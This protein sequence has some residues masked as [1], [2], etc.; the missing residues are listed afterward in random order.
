MQ[1][2][3]LPVPE[4]AADIDPAWLTGAL[5]LGGHLD[6]AAVIAVTAVP[7]GTGQVANCSRLTITYD[8]PTG[9][10]GTMIAKTGNTDPAL[11]QAIKEHGVYE[12]EVG[13]YRELAPHLDIPVARSYFADLDVD[14]GTFVLLLDD[15]APAAQGD[16][17]EGCSP[18]VATAAVEALVG[19]H[20]PRWGD[21]TL[22]DLAWLARDRDAERRARMEA[23]PVVWTSFQK[24]Y[25][26]LISDDVVVAGDSLMANLGGF[27]HGDVAMP[28][29][30]THQDY[31]LDNMLLGTTPA[32]NPEVYVVDWQT[33]RP[34]A[35][36]EDL[37]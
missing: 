15:L 34:G 10:P 11:R 2:V 9:C 36:V 19:L 7:V 23:L 17:I 35:G 6:S 37:A 31:R 4:T 30:I 12:R 8:A 27:L 29:T 20:A 25:A 22:H 3:N 26:D 13:F 14:D 16:Q 21:G 33:C 32:G 1:E 24:R 18:E 28:V 5:R